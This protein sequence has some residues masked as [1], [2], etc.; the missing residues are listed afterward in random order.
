[1]KTRSLGVGVFVLA[2]AIASPTLGVGGAQINPGIIPPEAKFHGASYG[3]W[4]AGWWQWAFS[5]PFDGHPLN[6]LTGADA[7]SGQSGHVWFL[8]GLWWPNDGTPPPGTV[9]RHITVPAGTA[10]FFPIVNGENNFVEAPSAATIEELWDTQAWLDAYGNQNLYATI[11]GRPLLNLTAYRTPAPV[12][13][14][15]LPEGNALEVWGVDF[16]SGCIEPV[17]ADGFFL[18]VQP[19]SVGTHEITFG[20]KDVGWTMD[21]VYDITVVPG[22]K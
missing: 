16:P 19:L 2:L 3:E 15:C 22:R 4:S 11:D 7:S 8:G 21:I 6:D 18:M 1:M 20:V 10:L 5:L 17:V 12:F 9:T 14:V 13:E